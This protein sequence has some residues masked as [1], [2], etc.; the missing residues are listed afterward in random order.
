MDVFE[1]N[2]FFF[3]M[4][5]KLKTILKEDVFSL[6]K[7]ERLMLNYFALFSAPEVCA[8]AAFYTAFIIIRDLVV[9]IL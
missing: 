2:F 3:R 8:D 4:A 6:I 7:A 1:L 5:F 9:I